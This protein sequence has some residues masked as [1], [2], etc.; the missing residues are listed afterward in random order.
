MQSFGFQQMVEQRNMTC[1]HA[2][3]R[4][5]LD[6]VLRLQAGILYGHLDEF[7]KKVMEGEKVDRLRDPSG[8]RLTDRYLSRNISQAYPWVD[9]V[10]VATSGNI[11]LSARHIHLSL[12]EWD[13]TGGFGVRIDVNDRA[14]SPELFLEAIEGFE[15]ITALIIE[16]L[17]I[18][19][20]VLERDTPR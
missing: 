6:T 1:A 7:A 16:Q 5:Q 12:G 4:L 15:A 14:L 11:H 10:Y 13:E 18:W 20:R 9:R 17:V 2:L 19:F 8:Q 3:V